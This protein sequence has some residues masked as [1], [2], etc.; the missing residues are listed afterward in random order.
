MVRDKIV[1]RAVKECKNGMYAN[2]GIGIP[3]LI[4]NFL[5]SDVSITL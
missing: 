1:Q 3:T 5:P 2:L 4:P